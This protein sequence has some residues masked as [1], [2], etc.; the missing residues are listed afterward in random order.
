M[1]EFEVIWDKKW[2]DC[3]CP[4]IEIALEQNKIDSKSHRYKHWDKVE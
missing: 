4:T 1:K 2:T 3:W